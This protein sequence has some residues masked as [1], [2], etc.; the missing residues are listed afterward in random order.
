MVPALLA[1]AGSTSSR[2]AQTRSISLFSIGA[3]RATE[4]G[5]AG[6]STFAISRRSTPLKPN[7]STKRAS[8]GKKEHDRRKY[9]PFR[10]SVRLEDIM[11][12][13]TQGLIG[14]RP[15]E[16]RAASR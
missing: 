7:T 5:G 3:T 14:V 4:P 6:S 8:E 15:A 12:Q 2:T 9:A 10:G 11:T 13:G 1:R 16:I